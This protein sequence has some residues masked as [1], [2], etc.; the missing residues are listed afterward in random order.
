[1][2]EFVGGDG[3]ALPATKGGGAQGHGG[4]GD[5]GGG[6][7]GDF[8]LLPEKFDGEHAANAKSDDA[9]VLVRMFRKDLLPAEIGQFI[10]DGTRAGFGVGIPFGAEA[11]EI[12]PADHGQRDTAGILTFVSEE[13][14]D[15]DGVSFPGEALGEF[16]S[17][18]AQGDHLMAEENGWQVGAWPVSSVGCLSGEALAGNEDFEVARAALHGSFDEGLALIFRRFWQ[19]GAIDSLWVSAVAALRR[20][21]DGTTG[22]EPAH[23]A[24]SQELSQVRGEMLVQRIRKVSDILNAVRSMA[25]LRGNWTA[26]LTYRGQNA[27]MRR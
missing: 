9:E 1:L 17:V 13:D 21:M 25:F 27:E 24:E 11:G 14:R 12:D 4:F 16:K 26:R 20:Q 3:Q 5:D 10:G 8:P 22:G 15:V 19:Q 6:E 18:R 7:A 23:Q 2:R